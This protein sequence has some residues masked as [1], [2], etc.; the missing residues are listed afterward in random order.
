MM[1]GRLQLY[2]EQTYLDVDFTGKIEINV[3]FKAYNKGRQYGL[4]L[5]SMRLSDGY[6]KYD[7]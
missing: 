6:N 4:D 7:I 5:K 2:L 3:Y 1:Q